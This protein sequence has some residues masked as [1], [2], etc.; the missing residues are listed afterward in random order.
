[1]LGDGRSWHAEAIALIK[2]ERLPI[3][4]WVV[5]HGYLRPGLI[6]IEPDGMGGSSTIP[7]R[8]ATSRTAKDAPRPNGWSPSFLR[9][10]AMDVAYHMSN[11]AASWHAYPYYTP[12]SG[13]PPL[14]EY[15]G[16]VR[17]AI[18]IP[19]RWRSRRETLASIDAAKGPLFLL[20]LQLSHDMQLV[21]YGISEPQ[22]ETLH[23]VVGSF[24]SHAAPDARLIVKVHPL[25]NGLEN[26]RGMLA[27]HAP[28]VLYLDGGDLDQ[29][30]KRV[31][32]VVTINST[33]GLS[34]VRAGAPTL[35]LGAS[36]YKSAGLTDPQELDTFWT[37]PRAPDQA[38]VER[39]CAFLQE[40]FHVPGAF[41]GPGALVG[42][43]ELADWLAAPPAAWDAGAA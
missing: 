3:K 39:F 31:A 21:R 24:L 23:R 19:A 9:Y 17:K 12:H 14:V 38:L 33:V 29:L 8:F 18:A 13:I 30:L 11:V 7:D 10:A 4:I 15:G 36:V 32:G 6:L 28:R 2:A 34:A 5:E 20:P 1:M 35:A 40:E 41:D 25:D 27:G 26:W 42:G 43:E 37:A 22:I 16:W